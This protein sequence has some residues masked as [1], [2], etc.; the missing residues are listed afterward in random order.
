MVWREKIVN[1]KDFFIQEENTI[2]EAMTKLDC[3]AKKVLFIVNGDKLL[4]ALT[5]GDIRRW[6]LTGGDLNASVSNV[7]NYNPV[8]LMEDKRRE[9][10]QYMK[11][12]KIDA[13]PVL[14]EKYQVVSI[15]LRDDN[16]ILQPANK[17]TVPVVIMAGGFGKRLYPYTKIL[18]K[19]LIPIGDIPISE[20]IINQFHSVGCN[21]FYMIVNHKKN[22][23]KAYFNEIKKDY[24]LSYVDEDVPLGT[25]GGLALLKGKIDVPFILSNCDILIT[26]DFHKIVSHHKEKGNLITMICSL[27]NFVIPYGVVKLGDHGQIETLE[28]KPQLSFFTNTG[29]YIVEPEVIEELEN[30]QEIGFPDIIEKYNV[31]GRKIGIYPIGENAWMDMGQID[32][33]NHMKEKMDLQ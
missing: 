12:Y 8:Y 9:A 30:G 7:A 28:E 33:L 23:I 17:L 13:L 3:V 6:I 14:N 10:H 32:E 24:N 11:R 27:K 2:I 21:D 5:D 16:E 15:V 22:M 29:C 18:P 1:I 26:E 19:P 4:A 20:H 25:G 31:Q